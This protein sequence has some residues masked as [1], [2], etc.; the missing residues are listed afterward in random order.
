MTES[1]NKNKHEGR[2]KKN[3]EQ[4][5]NTAINNECAMS[6]FLNSQH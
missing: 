2:K 5:L 4:G 3:Y 6:K 1:E